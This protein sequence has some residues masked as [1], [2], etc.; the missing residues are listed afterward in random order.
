[1]KERRIVKIKTNMHEYT[2]FKIIDTMEERDLIHYAWIRI[3]TLAG[4][5]NREGEL[6][7]SSNILYTVKTLALEFNRSTEKIKLALDVFVELEMVE[8]NEESVYV[9]KNFVKHQNIKTKQKDTEVK[10]DTKNRNKSEIL[11]LDN[12]TSNNEDISIE[13]EIDNI[14][15]NSISKSINGLDDKNNRNIENNNTILKKLYIEENKKHDL[16]N[17][18]IKKENNKKCTEKKKSP[19]KSKSS[20]LNMEEE[21]DDKYL[22]KFYDK[23]PEL[24]EGE[25]VIQSWNFS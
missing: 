13:N 9:V 12:D 5:V 6:Y 14:N 7:M 4:K 22:V 19:H 24:A 21:D 23:E 20:S 3:I 17:D 2:K 18:I 8:V 1:M 10:Q 15:I 16:S 11:N 25:R